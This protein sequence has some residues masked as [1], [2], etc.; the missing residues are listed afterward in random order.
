[1]LRIPDGHGKTCLGRENLIA[2]MSEM[3]NSAN[4]TP[5]QLPDRISQPGTGTSAHAQTAKSYTLMAAIVVAIAYYTGAK[6]GFT[7]TFQPHPISSLWPPN[8]LLLAGL[9]LTPTRAWW[10]LILAALP[11]HLA[12]ELQSGV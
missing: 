9:L 5:V 8:S 3:S 6:V 1:M 12:A 2:G 11:A 7:L 4:T 10:M